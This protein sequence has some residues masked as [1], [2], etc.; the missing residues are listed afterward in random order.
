MNLDDIE[1]NL[2]NEAGTG[3]G[4][5]KI[6]RMNHSIRVKPPDW[7]LACIEQGETTDTDMSLKHWCNFTTHK[8]RKARKQTSVTHFFKQ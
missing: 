6:E 5:H 1:D 2:D 3:L 7:V 4:L 8:R